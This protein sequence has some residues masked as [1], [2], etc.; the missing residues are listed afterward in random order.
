MVLKLGIV[1][2]V[3]RFWERN[4]EARVRQDRTVEDRKVWFKKKEKLSSEI[5]KQKAELKK[6]KR[7]KIR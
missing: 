2:R 1:C 6:E 4:P 7:A 5:K 3:S